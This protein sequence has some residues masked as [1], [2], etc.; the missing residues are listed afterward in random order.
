MYNHL[1]PSNAKDKSKYNWI[2]TKNYMSYLTEKTA[3]LL[4][5]NAI[6]LV[7]IAQSIAPVKAQ[8]IT[9]AND[10]TGT[11]VTSNG[12]QI[13][14][15]GG[16]LSKDGANLYQS[17]QKLGLDS[18]Q[19]ANFLSNPNI[20][21]ILGRVIGGSP[22]YINGLLQVIGG[23]SNLFLMN[24]AGIVFGAN[25]SLNVPSDFTATTANSIWLGA[26]KFNAVGSNDYANLVGNP[27]GFGFSTFQTGSIVNFSTLAVN[28]GNNLN[29][30]GGT[31][32]S[33]GNLSAPGGNIT[34]ASVPGQNLLRIS[35]P[36]H[37]LSLEVQSPSPTSATPVTLVDLLTGINGGNANSVTV[38][39]NGQV[40]L[41][42]SG[43]TVNTG[44]VVAKNITAQ[45]ATLSANKN[46]TLVTSQLETTGN[47]NLLAKDTVRIRDSISNPFLAQTGRNL[48]IQGN[49]SIDILA[50]NHPQTPFVSGGNLSLVSDGNISG[51]AHF[52]SGGQFF[53]RNLSGGSGNF[54]SYYDPIIKATGNVTFG[55]YTGVALKVETRGDIQ[56]GNIRIT[57][58]DTSIAAS[59]PDQNVL[60]TSSALILRAGLSSVT[61]PSNV[62]VAN[63]G[64][65]F[66]PTTPASS[67]GSIQVGN[68]DTSSTTVGETV[69]PITLF[70][71]GD[72]TTGTLN[73]SASGGNAGNGGAISL[74]ST[75]GSINIGNNIDSSGTAVGG[76][77][78]FTGPVNLAAG[79]TN[80]TT[81]NALV[82]FNSTVNGNSNLTVD[83]GTG[84]V[85]FEG[86]VGGITALGD[87]AVNSTGITK[88]G[89]SVKA[90]SLTT[91]TGGTTEIGG[92]I[93]TTGNQT[94]NDAVSLGTNTTL[95]G[96]QLTVSTVDGQNNNLT[97]DFAQGVT[98]SNAI[99]SNIKNFISQGAGGTNL[100]GDFTTAE[101]QTYN[102]AVTLDN[103]ITLDTDTGAGDI[104]F[105]GTVDGNKNLT[106]K[107]GTR[108]LTLDNAV[109][110]NSLSVTA[111]NTNI[112]NNIT[113]TGIQQFTGGV[114]LT[115]NNS[116][117]FNSNNN[118]INF[119]STINGSTSDLTLNAGT[120]NLTLGGDVNLNSLTANA[121][122]INAN[123]ANINA[124]STITGLGNA[125]INLL[126]NENISIR[127]ISTKG[128]NINL[129]SNTGFVKTQNIT[130]QGGNLDI[131]AQD[132]I[133]T[134]FLDTSS[135]TGNGGKVTLDSKGD[136]LDSK[137]DIEVTAI[138]TQAVPSGI[139]GDVNITTNNFFRATD[140]FIGYVPVN[141]SISTVGIKGSGNVTITH[142]GNGNT[143]F[144]VGNTEKIGTKGAIVS[145]LNNNIIPIR[146]Y[147]GNYTQ[148]NI[149]IITDSNIKETAEPSDK[150]YIL[151]SQSISTGV[152]K[153]D[154]GL[155]G[156]EEDFTNEVEKFSGQKFARKS[157]ADIQAALGKIQ[158]QTGIKSAIVYAK[159]SKSKSS[160]I[161]TTDMDEELL[162]LRILTSDGQTTIMLTNATKK[163]V[164]AVAKKFST[165]ISDVTSKS[166]DY[167]ESAQ[168]LYRWLIK[169][170]EAELQKQGITNLSFVMDE[171]LR[172]IPI[173]ALHDGE[174]FLI[175]KY[176][177]GLIPSTT[178]TNISYSD[179][180][181][182]QVLAMGASEFP[183]ALK[184]EN[185]API[186]PLPAVEIEVPSI[187]ELWDGKYFLNDDFTRENLKNKRQNNPV[188]NKP[189]E[190]VHLATHGEFKDASNSYIL[191]HDGQLPLN[192]V[193]DLGWNQPPLELLV[194][195]ACK[196]ASGDSKTE[197]GF[198]GLA[199]ITGVK[200]A[201]GSLWSVNDA[202]T[203]VFMTEFYRQLKSTSIKAEAIRQAQLAMINGNVKLED[204]KLI[205]T[206]RSVDITRKISTQLKDINLSH[207]YY[208]SAF[209]M[210]G[211]QW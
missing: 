136:I 23:N 24:P 95:K 97:L 56:G 3:L 93:T 138:N 186:Q 194:L 125:S 164:Q 105:N 68:I 19:I 4:L 80:I 187:A 184:R 201:V 51:D 108:N 185:E 205:A 67:T 167:L 110:V 9:P 40:A 145:A 7:T 70:A 160:D 98:V 63:G 128:Q 196:S 200:S 182:S 172:L 83:S 170:Y 54:L 190:M 171:G 28:P 44:D 30:I 112:A 79:A 191:L 150:S 158:A 140:T 42:G 188:T 77:I 203:L 176:S 208:W 135:K 207:P 109:N 175:K 166:N 103:N 133:K 168:Q 130:T 6:T 13:N 69:G 31:V 116:Q 163:N 210:I 199:V 22:S 131:Q 202:G 132:S 142:G 174:N 154:P 180:K 183:Q 71:K 173:A 17:F 119:S 143:P 89:S 141:A 192:K 148:G 86:I 99:Y 189:F 159:F 74:T 88:F 38:N 25:A 122:N 111:A 20:Q 33:T 115:G 204:N 37:L 11:V 106:L 209:M 41:T 156:V 27:N 16:T 121:A 84:K 52:Y 149:K 62:P 34:V 193:R 124:N 118:G 64:T 94:Y 101:G 59:D 45:S 137:G 179:I 129:K 48:Y 5:T 107:A 96:N 127:D 178:S 144:L 8:S 104:I 50:L 32:V 165:E 81:N 151:Q 85:S 78:S 147:Q 61:S 195:S 117:T 102:N 198:A 113:T 1:I 49:Q 169:P 72:I 92:D 181:K 57:G 100:T 211:S 139:G 43:L 65:N 90:N 46:L 114:T 53:I 26:N 58:K 82:S 39:S 73:A 206:N 55:N 87:L 153:A 152:T 123:A 197:L 21:N 14:I 177:L 161:L 146:L 60:T 29:L 12:N 15:S 91:N 10:G 18:N 47:L 134:R 75:N 35:Q 126:A 36:G 2:Y 162:N 155:A 157:L 120:G 76:N 66:T